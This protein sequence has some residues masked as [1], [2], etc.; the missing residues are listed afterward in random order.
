MIL[1][2]AI[3]VTDP[4]TGEPI[5][6]AK[7]IISSFRHAIKNK[8]TREKTFELLGYNE[9]CYVQGQPSIE[10][11]PNIIK[12]LHRINMIEDNRLE[13]VFRN[14]QDYRSH[15]VI[16]NSN[17]GPSWVILHISDYLGGE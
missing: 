4:I 3:R 8:G 13:L 14:I 15:I 17:K 6:G 2:L 7:S 1:Q 12:K 5:P 10:V 16:R 11:G 9:E